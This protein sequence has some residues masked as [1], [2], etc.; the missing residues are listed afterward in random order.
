MDNTT[1]TNRIK[2]RRKELRLTQSELAQKVGT[3]LM[4][5]VRWEKGERTPNISIMPK[6]AEA[7]N[8]SVAYLM[9]FDDDKAMAK[10]KQEL[11]TLA[12]NIAN[13]N[14]DLK[15]PISAGMNENMIIITDWGNKRTYS[16]PNNEEGRKLFLSVLASSLKGSGSALVSNSITGDNNSDIQQGIVNN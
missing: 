5:I 8:T 4:T 16:F 13:E 7:L 15:A 3:S 9:G 2:T 1:T 12:T 6:L 11:L 10:Q 14:I